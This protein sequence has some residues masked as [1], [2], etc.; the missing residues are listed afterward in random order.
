MRIFVMIITLGPIV[1]C[2]LH[3]QFNKHA[4]VLFLGRKRWGMLFTH[5]FPRK[6]ALPTIY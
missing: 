1:L 5:F 2:S 4:V 3:M 6:N